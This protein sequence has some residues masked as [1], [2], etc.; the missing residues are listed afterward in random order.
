MDIQSALHKSSQ[1]DQDKKSKFS[2]AVFAKK[3]EF[4]AVSKKRI[5]SKNETQ[6]F[7]KTFQDPS[8][9]A[10][11]IKTD[12]KNQLHKSL[13]SIIHKIVNSE[14]SKRSLGNSLKGKSP[15]QSNNV[16]NS[17]TARKKTNK[18]KFTGSRSDR[19]GVDGQQIV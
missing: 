6:P 9:G 13:K 1:Q 2:K 17:V 8:S 7:K 4:S 18:K 3:N 11:E 5:L 10:G 15:Y 19:Q 16:S 12:R 14:L